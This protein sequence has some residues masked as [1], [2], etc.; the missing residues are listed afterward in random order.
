MIFA[1][2]TGGNPV[3]AVTALIDTPAFVVNAFFNGATLNL[4]PLAPV[5]NP[6]VSAG[7]AGGRTPQR[8]QPRLL[9]SPGQG[10]L[11][12]RRRL[13]QVGRS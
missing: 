2:I 4:D 10:W 3:G 11:S 7:D 1:D 6:F 13:R 9:S 8:P 12:C 5:F